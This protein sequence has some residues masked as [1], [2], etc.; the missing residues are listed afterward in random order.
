MGAL[1]PTEGVFAGKADANKVFRTELDPVHFLHRAAYMYP[2]K[3]AVVDGERRYSYAALAQRSWRLA[4]SLRS[5]GLR[6]GDRV[7]TLLFN[8]SPMLEAHFGVPAGGR[9]S[10]RGQQPAGKPGRWGDPRAQRR[11]FSPARRR[12]R[13]PRR[14]AGALRPHGNSCRQR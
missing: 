5:A 3:I 9:D 7:A 10:R 4:N 2:E 6:K 12:A 8:S 13:V 14:T 1:A 11:A